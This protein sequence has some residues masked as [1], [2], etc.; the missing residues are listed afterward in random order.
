MDSGLSLYRKMGSLSTE[1]IVP[2]EDVPFLVKAPRLERSGAMATSFPDSSIVLHEDR[3]C[4]Q[5]MGRRFMG[6]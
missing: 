3:S 1:V 6:E 4:F 2:E 5:L